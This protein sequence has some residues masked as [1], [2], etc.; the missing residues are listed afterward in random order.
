MDKIECRPAPIALTSLDDVLRSLSDPHATRYTSVSV[1]IHN[2]SNGTR[3][4]LRT[5]VVETEALRRALAHVVG[6]GT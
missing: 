2:P 5:L 4:E 3:N 6:G 1:S